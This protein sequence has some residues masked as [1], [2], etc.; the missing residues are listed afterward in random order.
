MSEE[1]YTLTTCTRCTL[2]W[3]CPTEDCSTDFKKIHSRSECGALVDYA[4]VE[5]MK[6]DY[7]ISRQSIRQ[8]MVPAYPARS[9]F[10]L[11]TVRNWEEYCR[12]H[13]TDFHEAVAGIA[14]DSTLSRMNPHAVKAVGIMA[15]QSASIPLTMVA[16]LEKVIPDLSSR[17]RLCVHIVGASE[18]EASGKGMMEEVLHLLPSCQ[19]LTVGYIGPEAI[20]HENEG[21]LACSMCQGV[22]KTRNC[23][24]FKG[25]YH[26]FLQSSENTKPADFI[27]CFNTGMSEVERASWAP[28]LKAILDLKIPA[29]FTSYSQPEIRLEKILLDGLGANFVLQP[30]RNRWK[31]VIPI[32][33]TYPIAETN[34]KSW[35]YANYYWYIIRGRR[36]PEGPEVDGLDLV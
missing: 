36:G 11:S 31:G 33:N 22:G 21:E 35:S 10:P 34:E 3:H 15:K 25:P 17:R 1:Y 30:E 16:G 24:Y 18:R 9:Y 7:A 6:I 2:A 4:A 32:L 29:A 20:V 27:I 23:I 13:F 19:C 28:T 12:R 26:D 14:Q 5:R 8:L